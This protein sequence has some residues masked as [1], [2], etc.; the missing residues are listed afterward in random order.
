M[1]SLTYRVLRSA[2]SFTLSMAPCWQLLA[3]IFPAASQNTHRSPA[4]NWSAF[5]RLFA[6]N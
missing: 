1:K 3:E 5:G 2:V 6:M 4:K